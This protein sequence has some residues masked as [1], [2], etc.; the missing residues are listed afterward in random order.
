MALQIT[1][2]TFKDVLSENKLTVIDF[3]YCGNPVDVTNSDCVEF[4]LCEIHAED[5]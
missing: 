1:D 5:C 3:C 2:G 4:S